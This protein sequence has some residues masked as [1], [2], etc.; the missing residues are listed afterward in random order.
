MSTKYE[1]LI[2]EIINNYFL[3]KNQFRLISFSKGHTDYDNPYYL[4]YRDVELAFLSLNEGERLIIKNDFLCPKKA[5]WWTTYFDSAVYR[6]Y[7]MIAV[8]KF[9]RAF[10]EIH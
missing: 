1:R 10:Y 5:D 2:N 6:F 3:C 7:R 8:E 9:V 4:Y